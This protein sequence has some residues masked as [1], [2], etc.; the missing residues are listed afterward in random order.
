MMVRLTL[1][2]N[3][4]VRAFLAFQLHLS[5]QP[6]SLT[7]LGGA[8]LNN[9]VNGCVVQNLRE[10]ASKKTNHAS[11]IVNH[12]LSPKLKRKITCALISIL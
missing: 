1:M 3:T 8:P 9:K 12:I 10:A 11:G 6:I 2:N 5:I 7:V 4:K